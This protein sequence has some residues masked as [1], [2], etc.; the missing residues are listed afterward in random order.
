MSQA[1][2]SNIRS[3]CQF[4]KHQ[5][6]IPLCK[7]WCLDYTMCYYFSFIFLHVLI[8][9]CMCNVCVCTSSLD[10]YEFKN[11]CTVCGHCFIY[12]FDHMPLFHT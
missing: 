3:F 5:F 9:V 6:A 7:Q 8:S 2:D 1:V 11:T 10:K 12:C 4:L